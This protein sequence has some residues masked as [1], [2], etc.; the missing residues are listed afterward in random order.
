MVGRRDRRWMMG[1]GTV[2]CRVG[3]AAADVA[4]GIAEK[5]L[6][7]LNGSVKL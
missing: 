3:F 4:L 7:Y 6:R 2:V 5:N 1:R